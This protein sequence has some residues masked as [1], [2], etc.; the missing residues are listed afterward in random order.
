LSEPELVP[1]LRAQV[2]ARLD[3]ARECSQ[4]SDGH[5]WRRTHVLGDGTPVPV[6]ALYEG[7]QLLDWDGEP[8]H[9]EYTV[10][11]DEGSPGDAQFEHIAGNDPR[12][13]IARCESELAVLDE[14][15]PYACTWPGGSRCTTCASSEV[16]PN[17]VAVMAA[18]PCRTV[19]LLGRAYRH[20]AGYLEAWSP[21]G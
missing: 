3:L 11:Y 19:R 9:G 7:A 8:G 13:T 18:F 6:G 2:Q 20:H 1:W 16:Y 4:G 5:W 21:T 14:H 10:V 15:A 12:D 17:G